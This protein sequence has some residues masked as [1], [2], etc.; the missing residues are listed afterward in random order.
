LF[1]SL[2]KAFSYLECGYP[3]TALQYRNE[4][5]GFVSDTHPSF[6]VEDNTKITLEL[7]MKEKTLFYFINDLLFP[8]HTIHIPDGSYY[9]FVYFIFILFC[10]LFFIL[11]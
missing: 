2:F 10:F 3:S 8:F 7:N 9:F 5:D 11:D 4:Y 6:L 1:S